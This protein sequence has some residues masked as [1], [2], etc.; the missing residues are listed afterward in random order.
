MTTCTGH[1]SMSEHTIHAVILTVLF[2]A[3]G[4][5]GI[6]LLVWRDPSKIREQMRRE[7]QQ[8]RSNQ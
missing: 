3:L 6:A 4:P 1:S 5:G 7:A 2:V 8:N